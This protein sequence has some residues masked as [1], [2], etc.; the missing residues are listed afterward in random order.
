MSRRIKYAKLRLTKPSD[1]PAKT[2]SHG[3]DEGAPAPADEGG[4]SLKTEKSSKYFLHGLAETCS[5]QGTFVEAEVGETSAELVECDIQNSRR[6]STDVSESNADDGAKLPKLRKKAAAKGNTLISNFLNSQPIAQDDDFEESRPIAPPM[7]AKT[8]VQR[9]S[10]KT[11]SSRRP[12]NQSD[13]RKVFSKYKNDHEV[14][15]ELL[16]EH[17]ESDR[18]DPEQLQLAIAMSRS[19]AEC[20][21]TRNASTDNLSEQSTSDSLSST[22]RRIVGI[23]TTL[24]QFGFRCKNSYTDYDLNVIF[25]SAVCKNVK[26]IKHRRATN[27]IQRSAKDL[28]EY[29]ETRVKKIFP[30]EM[31]AIENHSEACTSPGS[32]LSHLF[33]I[34][35]TDQASMN[36]IEK[37][38]VPELLE[39]NPAPVGFMLKDWSKIPGREP[40]PERACSNDFEL[41]AADRKVEP[42]RASSPDLFED[43]ADAH[44]N[45]ATAETADN[46]EPCERFSI[47]DNHAKA[48]P[49][50]YPSVQNDQQTQ[51]LN[52]SHY[53]EDPSECHQ[54]NETNYRQNQTLNC[55]SSAD[56]PICSPTQCTALTIDY[57][58]NE[59]DKFVTASEEPQYAEGTFHHSTDN[60]FDD[61]DPDPTVDPDPIVSF[62]VY[63]SEE[64]KISAAS[65]VPADMASQNDCPDL[66][67]QSTSQ[68]QQDLINIPNNPSYQLPQNGAGCENIEISNSAS[69]VAK[70]PL[71]AEKKL[72]FHRIAI[73]A[74]LSEALEGKKDMIETVDLLEID[75]AEY[76][77]ESQCSMVQQ[78]MQDDVL[79]IS[80]DEV[81]YS[82][83]RLSCAT[84]DER[85]LQE[86]EQRLDEDPEC[87]IIY[88]H[89]SPVINHDHALTSSLKPRENILSPSTN[90]LLDESEIL[91]KESNRSITENVAEDTIAY[92]YNLVKQFNLPPLGRQ[93]EEINEDSAALSEHHNEIS[94]L[95]KDATVNRSTHSTNDHSR[96]AK[97]TTGRLSNFLQHYE[98]PLFEE[99]EIEAETLTTQSSF[100]E[101]PRIASKNSVK[102]LK[103][104][105]HFDSPKEGGRLKRTASESGG[106][107]AS[108]P[109]EREQLVKMDR[110]K[111]KFE[112]LKLYSNSFRKSEFVINMVT[113]DPPNYDAMS[114]TE[115]ERELFKYGLKLLDP[116][117]AV[118]V[119]RHIYNEIHPFVRVVERINAVICPEDLDRNND[120]RDRQNIVVHASANNQVGSLHSRICAFKLNI[121]EP[122]IILSSKPRKKMSWC[123]VPLHVSFFN[124]ISENRMLQ[125]QIL[126]YEPVN[127]DYIHATLKEADLRYEIN[128]LIAFLDKHCIT[129][130]SAA[131]NGDRSKGR[132][133]KVGSK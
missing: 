3:V 30:A 70:E 89:D 114:V 50:F 78:E 5:S 126:R 66:V 11:T 103:S 106:F 36:I 15:Q 109:N 59:D 92:L 52:K 54:V 12:R 74:R 82:L 104:F 112:H 22:E 90:E 108:T 115:I 28:M 123:T 23:R 9:A 122:N 79:E 43:C 68:S 91:Q 83:R 19:L 113:E 125:R 65:K 88:Q 14:L 47:G 84:T 116:E 49:Q 61:T 39:M 60:I 16:K 8:K 51:N 80:D 25:G 7:K 86:V 110:F 38:Y 107:S 124:M 118:K 64:E 35:Q 42:N 20:D 71:V 40:T 129:F 72:S 26:K 130:R 117:K 10:K 29:I 53:L 105:H 75:D 99:H 1:G 31:L 96:T 128:D 13:I 56:R 17:S 45:T 87:T 41:N 34:A 76:H 127:L 67:T 133:S 2:C 81:N 21:G 97:A 100:R 62:E 102:R 98:E 32:C 85:P 24:E 48:V 4:N 77:S 69:P 27:L 44:D 33:W 119:L 63:S 46:S 94:C 57:D 18:I 58:S 131:S 111:E 101:V 121:D 37:Y 73:K 6:R 95:S 132:G 120:Q 55:S 93:K